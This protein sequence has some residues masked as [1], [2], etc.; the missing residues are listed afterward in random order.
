MKRVVPYPLLLIIA[1]V[2]DR[3]SISVMQIGALESLR[4]LLILLLIAIASMLVIQRSI[5]DWQHTNF[6]VFMAVVM[7]VGYRPIYA[8]LKV[9][10]PSYADEL[11]LALLPFLGFL[12]ALI[13]RRRTWKRIRN[14]AQLTHYFNL[15]FVFLLVFQGMR[16]GRDASSFF[17]SNTNAP[18]PAIS[19]LT[20]RIQLKPET[21]P[22]IYIIILDGY[23][24]QDVLRTIYNHD[25][26]KF[27]SQL[28]ARGF[29][30]AAASH[31]NYV[32]TTYAVASLM[33]FDYVQ[34]WLPS[35]DYYQYLV[36]PVQENRV[37]QLLD[38]IGYTTVSF[39]GELTYTEIKDSDVYLSKFLPLNK[40]ESLFLVDSPFEPLSNIFNL[41]LPIPGYKAHRE[42]IRYALNELKEIPASTPGPK[43]VYTH[44]LAPH[45]PFVFDGDGNAIQQER[46]Y[47]VWD[48][49]FL[50]GSPQ[51]YWDGY[52]EQVMFL[53]GEII[54]TIDA[55]LA[56]SETPPVILLMGDHGPG[57][58]FHWNVDE[59]GC[60]WERTSNLYALRLPDP[61]GERALYS[62]ISP[63][64]TFRLVFNTY[65]GTS[66][67]LLEDRTYLMSAQYRDKVKDV[68]DQRDSRQGCTIPDD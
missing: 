33:N 25:N 54:K 65:F 6:I 29:Y 3:V 7:F 12:Y 5:N 23:G 11:A 1:V 30:V 68:T 13:V 43:I 32:Q 67:P 41:K 51:E 61:Q 27:I 18:M 16:L 38:Q 63:V 28:R 50:E 49:D 24:R 21:R 15:V 40:F 37:Y 58:M 56:K 22:D 48:A 45:P 8:A 66:L 42:R 64:N 26:S 60:L 47:R 17:T 46:P 34:P 14:A 4:P 62:S 36:Q 44:I 55:I 9:K 2:L 35:Y 19:P 31:S 53:N 20:E 52:R 39:E 59:P 10:N 57:S